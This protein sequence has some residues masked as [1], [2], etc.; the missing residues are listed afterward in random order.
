MQTAMFIILGYL[1]GS[2]LYARLFS[3]LLKK[4]DVIE[5]SKDQN[6]GAANAFMYGGFGCGLCTLV[7]DILK[8]FIPVWLYISYCNTAN[9]DLSGLGIVIASPVVGH[10]FPLFYKFK[11]GKGIATTFGCLLGLLPLW[12]PFLVL[13]V[14]FIF[15]STILRINPH[16]H[17]TLVTYFCSLLCMVCMV[18]NSAILLGFAIITL[19]VSARMFTS[20]EEKEKMRVELLWMH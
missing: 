3:R 8:G 13:V 18:K 5:K 19:A 11:G 1:S 20:K 15:F 16:F 4:D 6:P 9:M 14:F 10:V 17:R 7:C 2:I 12:Q